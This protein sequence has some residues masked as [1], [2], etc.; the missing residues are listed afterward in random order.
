MARDLFA[1]TPQGWSRVP[2]RGPCRSRVNSS[3]AV[4]VC[5]FTLL[6]TMLALII[7]LVGVLAVVQ[8]QRSFLS[9]NAWSSHSATATYL[10]NELREF[11]RALP[12]HDPTTGGLYLATPGDPATLTGWGPETGETAVDDINDLDD[13]DGLVLGEAT[14]FP[15]GFTM[16]RRL[17]GPINAFGEVISEV[18]WDGS[19]EMVEVGGHEQPVSM[20]GW[21]QIVQVHK[22]DPYDYS[23]VVDPAT[24]V[25]GIRDVG[26][27]PLRIT[28]TIL[29][30]GPFEAEAPAVTSVTWVVPP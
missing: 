22:V 16:R 28:V 6:E 26:S 15:A 25:A 1:L 13:L 27:Y 19:V 17:P 12:R 2:R 29:Y 18:L 23:Q 5:G 10:A 9:T 21:T 30:Q 8:A 4:W 7:V 14:S 24:Q 11:S 3:P 20:R